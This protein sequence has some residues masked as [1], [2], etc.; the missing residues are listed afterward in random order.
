MHIKVHWYDYG[1]YM[2]TKIESA[3]VV[4]LLHEGDCGTK[5]KGFI[6]AI[7]KKNSY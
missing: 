7:W 3:A 6:E 4:R 2:V 5:E 1:N